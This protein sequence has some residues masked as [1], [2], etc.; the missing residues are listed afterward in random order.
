MSSTDLV[1]A[2]SI[3]S[4]ALALLDPSA[5]DA[6]PYIDG[7]RGTAVYL[8]VWVPPEIL[9]AGGYHPMLL[10]GKIQ[11]PSSD[12]V[13]YRISSVAELL[14]SDCPVPD[15]KMI[16]LPDTC[17]SLLKTA[18]RIA[19][20]RDLRIFY[21]EE[22]F[23]QNDE[24]LRKY[25]H[26]LSW[27]CD[28][29]SV[30]ISQTDFN[31]RL[32]DAV[33]K[34][35]QV[36]S[37]LEKLHEERAVPTEIYYIL[38]AASSVAPP[39][40]VIPLLEKAIE[41]YP[42]QSADGIPRLLLIGAPC[43]IAEWELAS[44]VEKA[45]G[46]VVYDF[47]CTAGR[48]IRASSPVQGVSAFEGLALEY[49]NRLPCLPVEP[50][51]RFYS[52]VEREIATRGINGILFL[53]PESCAAYTN[54]KE[55]LEWQVNSPIFTINGDFIAADNDARVKLLAEFIKKLDK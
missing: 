46:K 5:F 14:D 51:A 2:D 12:K 30:G 28:F 31:R 25:V 16:A 7:Y 26:Q 36:R 44:L 15:L 27:M 38:A 9:R 17:Q 34:Y 55:R 8:C 49:F 52:E 10:R 21:I 23:C 32:E 37:L 48:I 47:I 24:C 29:V 20:K 41:H 4:Q 43:G 40:L 33:A 1:A 39:E 42:K 22:P 50:T 18:T 6:S 45:G 53:C 3:G 11:Q 19:Q 54:E 13:C 35:S